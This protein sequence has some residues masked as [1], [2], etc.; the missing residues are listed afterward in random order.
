M[1]T[2]YPHEADWDAIADA[3]GDPSWRADRMRSLVREAR[4]LRLQAA[5]AAATA[6]TPGSLDLLATL[7]LVSEKY[8]NRG[9]HGFAAGSVRRWPT[10]LAPRPTR[11]SA[12]Q[13]SLRPPGT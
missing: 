7:P 10:P 6:A 11:A 13:C 8:V 5:T 2:V 1:I 4:G 3:T 9:R 12:G